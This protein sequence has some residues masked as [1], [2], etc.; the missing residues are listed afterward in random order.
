MARSPL[1][2]GGHRPAGS[3]P[4]QPRPPGHRLGAGPLL[5]LGTYPVS[6]ATWILGTPAEVP[7][8][9]QPHPAGVNGQTSALLRDAAGSQGIVH[10]TLFGDTPTTATV[11][12]THAILSLPGPF[13]QPGDLVLTLA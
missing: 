5:D 7:A 10:T 4:R 3:D 9:A 1:H 6:R 2:E 8:F 11:T 12:G 13:H